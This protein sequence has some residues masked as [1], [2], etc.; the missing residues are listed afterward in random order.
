M[1][2]SAGVVLPGP[3]WKA[4][5]GAVDPNLIDNLAF[6]LTAEPGR[7]S[8]AVNEGR[9]SKEDKPLLENI[10]LELGADP[11]P[12]S[13][14]NVQFLNLDALK[15]AARGDVDGLQRAFNWNS[16]EQGDE[17]WRTQYE[18]GKVWEE[19]QAMLGLWY[20]RAEDSSRAVKWKN[21]WFGPETRKAFLEGD[22]DGVLEHLAEHSVPDLDKWEERL[23]RGSGGAI[24]ELLHAANLHYTLRPWDLG[25]DGPR[26]PAVIDALRE[27]RYSEALTLWARELA[28]EGEPP[29][30]AAEVL[31]AFQDSRGKVRRALARRLADAHQAVF[32]D[33]GPGKPPR[34]DTRGKYELALV[35]VKA[36]NWA[37]TRSYLMSAA[38]ARDGSCPRLPSMAWTFTNHRPGLERRLEYLCAEPKETP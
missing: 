34:A 30:R 37:S 38:N 6:S 16:T 20:R 29:K 19:A 9:L 22:F 31:S 8:N 27:E 13:A 11:R 32:L 35:Y 33:Y 4:T 36:G 26:A 17:F 15:G 5:R 1:E 18:D 10:L 25:L 7:W 12:G 28:A 21:K 2:S 14:V 24:R 3:L 23:E